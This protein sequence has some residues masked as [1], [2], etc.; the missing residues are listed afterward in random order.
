M[1]DLNLLFPL[2]CQRTHYSQWLFQ[3]PTQ[4]NT[5]IALFPFLAQEET[6]LSIRIKTPNYWYCIILWAFFSTSPRAL[7]VSSKKFYSHCAMGRT[8]G[9]AERTIGEAE[10]APPVPRQ[11]GG[12]RQDLAQGLQ[13]QSQSSGW[14]TAPQAGHGTLCQLLGWCQGWWLHRRGGAGPGCC[15][16]GCCGWHQRG[17]AE[18]WFSPAPRWEAAARREE[19]LRSF[20]RHSCTAGKTLHSDAL[21]DYGPVELPHHRESSCSL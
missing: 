20:E 8:T 19:T 2:W 11:G 5:P 14:F 6:L 4:G 10:A 16:W 12:Q 18:V 1:T 13:G 7:L 9:E 21:R 15:S 17:C 3:V